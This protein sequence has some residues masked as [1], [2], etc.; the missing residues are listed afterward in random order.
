MEKKRQKS[1]SRQA[2]KKTAR[3]SG[4]ARFGSRPPRTTD[5]KESTLKAHPPFFFLLGAAEGGRASRSAFCGRANHRQ[6]KNKRARGYNCF[7]F[8]L[9]LV[10]RRR[11]KR[12]E[13]RAAADPPQKV[14]GGRR[15]QQK[16]LSASPKKRRRYGSETVVTAPSRKTGRTTRR[17]AA[18][19]T[20]EDMA[21][22]QSSALE[23]RLLL[24]K[25]LDE[26]ARA[27]V[28]RE[29]A[30][31][32]RHDT[33]VIT[34][35]LAAAWPGEGPRQVKVN[36]LQPV[37]VETRAALVDLLA[38]MAWSMPTHILVVLDDVDVVLIPGGDLYF[39]HRLARV[40]PAARKIIAAEDTG[41]LGALC[42]FV[43]HLACV[44]SAA[45]RHRILLADGVTEVE[46]RAR[47]IFLRFVLAVFDAVRAYLGA[48]KTSA[49]DGV[50]GSSPP[51][52]DPV[53]PVCAPCPVP[54]DTLWPRALAVRL[55]DSGARTVTL[56]GIIYEKQTQGA[57]WLR[58]ATHSVAL[59]SPG[60]AADRLT[61]DYCL[62]GGPLGMGSS[63]V[64]DPVVDWAAD[65]CL[66]VRIEG[67][68][69]LALEH[70][71]AEAI[72]RCA[73]SYM[74]HGALRAMLDVVG[75]VGASP[76]IAHQTIVPTVLTNMA[77]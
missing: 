43:Q 30:S 18:R 17:A 20:D 4:R 53:P 52:P 8:F 51:P 25:R 37:R 65:L 59:A 39:A 14:D 62:S 32:R 6:P 13:A 64:R 71:L 76:R 5:P 34:Q 12:M 47:P 42:A 70:A 50:S 9:L 74:M 55:L 49:D 69:L 57:S 22:S 41:R 56:P 16:A 23:P 35:C 73:P 40:L 1:D 19:T 29:T 63:L 48:H 72:A 31:Q 36:E 66:C 75:I 3:D 60:A 33:D 21:P 61:D 26:R 77:A 67:A 54:L 24:R 7:P 44:P 10:E 28:D 2:R 15:T 46:C 68:S 58:R 38:T 11:K 27:R 45:T